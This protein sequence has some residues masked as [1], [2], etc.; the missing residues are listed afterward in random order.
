MGQLQLA[1]PPGLSKTNAGSSTDEV[2]EF[3]VAVMGIES[4]DLWLKIAA[5]FENPVQ[6][7]PTSQY[8][9]ASPRLVRSVMIWK[10]WSGVRKPAG[11]QMQ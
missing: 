11:A 1:Y 8:G 5:V 9:P 2:S 4:K 3:H 6:P 10:R 7:V